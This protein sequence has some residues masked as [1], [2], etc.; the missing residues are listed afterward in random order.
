MLVVGP[1]GEGNVADR[2]VRE[3]S[4]KRQERGWKRRVFFFVFLPFLG[5]LS[6]HVEVPRLGVQSEL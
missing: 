5:L 2:G 6:R 4:A 3:V 1:L